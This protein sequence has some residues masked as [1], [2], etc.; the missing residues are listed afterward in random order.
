MKTSTNI[1]F[2]GNGHTMGKFI[3]TEEEKK[4]IMG[5]YE[6]SSNPQKQAYS[7]LIGYLENLS[8]SGMGSQGIDDMAAIKEY[9]VYLENLRDGKPSSTLSGP[10][11]IVKNYV[12]GKIRDLSVSEKKKLI[13]LGQNLH[14]SSY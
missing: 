13:E 2:I 12:N 6:Q 8:K 11:Q 9:R 10:A 1:I 4:H 5:L 3:I 14:T 7:M